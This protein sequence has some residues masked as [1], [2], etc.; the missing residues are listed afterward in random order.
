MNVSILTV[1]PELYEP[2]LRTSL[3]GRAQQNGLVSFHIQRFA[4]WAEPKK[5]IDAPAFGHGAGMLIKP[6]MVEKVVEASEQNFGRAFRIVLSPQG[7]RLD[8]QLLETIVHRAQERSHLMLITARY[9]GLDTRVEQEYA[10]LVVSIGDFVLMGGDLPA[11]VLLEG[12][13]RLM[14]DVVGRKESVEHESFSGP[15]LDYPTYTEPV[16]WK[17]RMVPDIVRS[18]NH[19]AVDEWRKQQAAQKTIRQRFD[20]FRSQPVSEA[21]KQLGCAYIPPHYVALMHAD[22]LVGSEREPGVTSVTS[23]DIHD[24]ARS[25]ATYGIRGFSIVTPLYDQQKIVERFLHF[26]HEGFGKEYN[27]SRYQAMKHTDVQPGI[28]DVIARIEKVEGK[29]P[30]L[31]ATSARPT[32]HEKEITYHDQHRVWQFDRPVLLIFGTGQGLSPE[33]VEQCDFVLVPVEGC[34]AYNHLSVR[35]AAAIVL[36]RWLGLNPRHIA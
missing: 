9:E 28:Q 8:Q 17:G 11:M 27:E 3:I 33:L 10:D 16:E 24:I 5:R 31:I 2:F 22:V 36:D 35:S 19:G 15:F 6:D 29:K 20:W 30:I 34:T 18:G 12:M 32:G 1:F 25:S 21:D 7:E 23:V 14:P 26:W 13:L 4:D